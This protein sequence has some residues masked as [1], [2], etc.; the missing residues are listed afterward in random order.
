MSAPNVGR[1]VEMGSPVVAQVSGND[2]LQRLDTHAASLA[3]IEVKVDTIPAEIARLDASDRRHTEAI[4]ELQ[5]WRSLWVGV[6]SVVTV[7]LGSG[8]VAALITALH[9]GAR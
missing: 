9:H 2:L 7:I 6:T 3:R 1:A 5:R 8:L 4:A